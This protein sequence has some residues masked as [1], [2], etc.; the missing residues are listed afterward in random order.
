MCAHNR[1]LNNLL[2]KSLL[3]I[4]DAYTRFVEIGG[5][6]LRQSGIQIVIGFLAPARRYGHTWSI[7]QFF[8]SEKW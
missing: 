4:S 2:W 1:G 6:D 7:T 5:R 8:G 3:K